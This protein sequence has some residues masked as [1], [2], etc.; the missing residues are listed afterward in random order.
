[1]LADVRD[2]S[3]VTALSWHCSFVAG[4]NCS[5][6][7]VMLECWPRPC[8]LLLVACQLVMFY[9]QPMRSAH[10]RGDVEWSVGYRTQGWH[11]NMSREGTFLPTLPRLRLALSLLCG[12]RCWWQARVP[13][14]QS[15]A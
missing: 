14:R 11:R 1:M 15:P 2:S 12:V 6:S 13:W 10:S 8:S 7:G 9:A 3:S 4:A 5:H